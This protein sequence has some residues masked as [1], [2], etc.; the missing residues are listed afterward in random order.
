M[1]FLGYVIKNNKSELPDY[2]ELSG[3]CKRDSG[4]CRVKG[5]REEAMQRVGLTKA[6]LFQS[7]RPLGLGVV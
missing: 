6:N 1:K 3:S 5:I 7:L 2:P 4:T